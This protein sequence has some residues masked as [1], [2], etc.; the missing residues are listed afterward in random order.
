MRY[1]S[2]PAREAYEEQIIK[3][4]F[5]KLY[6]PS[7]EVSIGPGAMLSTASVDL[8]ELHAETLAIAPDTA[9]WAFLDPAEAVSFR[10]VNGRP[11]AS[12]ARDW[13]ADSSAGAS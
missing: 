7:G 8:I 6:E 10:A 5:G 12:L 9:S 13:A 11:F 1:F 2:T 4:Q 3:S